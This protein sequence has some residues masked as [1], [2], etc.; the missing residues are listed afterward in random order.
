M[1][2]ARKLPHDRRRHFAWPLDLKRARILVTN[3]DGIYA[4]GMEVMEKIAHALSRDVWVVAPEQEQSGAGHSL[5]LR[6]PL[7]IREHSERRFSVDGT[8]TDC[9]LLAANKILKDH[10]PDLVLSGVNRGA[11]LGEDVTYSGTVAAAME[12]TL[13]GFPAIAFSQV[14]GPGQPAKWAT[15]EHHAPAL[16]RRLVKIGWPRQTLL[17]VNF[18][19]A[20]ADSVNGVMISRQG[21]RKIGDQLQEGTDPW[22]RPY[23]WI[24]AMRSKETAKPG[25]DYAATD[26]LAISVTPVHMDMTAAKTVKTLQ[27]AFGQAKRK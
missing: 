16:I 5:T 24:G 23:Y 27:Q 9:V 26:A 4:P 14:V 1:S 22:G 10:P 12:A 3:D 2:V 19:D 21:S 25:T 20:V 18:P 6:R 13:L 7:R 17:N 8:P 15:A 11:N